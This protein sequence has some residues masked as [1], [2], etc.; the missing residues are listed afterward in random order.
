[1][2][3]EECLN[4]MVI[5]ID[6]REKENKH[7]TDIF[8]KKNIRYESKKL[9]FG[10]YSFYIDRGEYS[11]YFTSIYSIERKN[12]LDEISQNF[13]KKR[14]QFKNEF[15]LAKL[16]NCKI[17]LFIENNNYTDIQNH[18]YRSQL[19]PK[20]FIASLHTWK[21]RYD[22]DIIFLSKESVA[23]YIYN[24]FK[25]FLFENQDLYWDVI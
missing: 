18:K 3:K 5:L 9:D 1:M 25:Y 17:D 16:N 15:E 4:N 24:C 10:D 22:C 12:S 6:T 23:T 8:D 2:T 21:F 19:N 14:E 7:I 13:T 11:L 20:S